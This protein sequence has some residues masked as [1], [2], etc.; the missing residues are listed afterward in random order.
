MPSIPIFLPSEENSETSDGEEKEGGQEKEGEQEKDVDEEKESTETNPVLFKV[1][2]TIDPTQKFIEVNHEFIERR[3]KLLNINNKM[4]KYQEQHEK[5]NKKDEKEDF[6]LTQSLNNSSPKNEADFF[7]NSKDSLMTSHNMISFECNNTV[8][9]CASSDLEY[10]SVQTDPILPN[11]VD[12]EPYEK[13][14]DFPETSSEFFDNEKESFSSNPS[15]EESPPTPDVTPNKGYAEVIREFNAVVHYVKDH[16]ISDSYSSQV[17]HSFYNLDSKLSILAVFQADFNFTDYNHHNYHININ[18]TKSLSNDIVGSLSILVSMTPEHIHNATFYVF[19]HDK[20]P[21]IITKPSTEQSAKRLKLSKSAEISRSLKS[22]SF[23]QF[24]SYSTSNRRSYFAKGGGAIYVHNTQD[25]DSL[26][27]MRCT[28]ENNKCAGTFEI[29][30]DLLFSGTNMW[31]SLHDS[32][33]APQKFSYRQSSKSKGENDGLQAILIDSTFPEID[34]SDT[35]FVA[36]NTFSEAPPIVE[37]NNTDPEEDND[38]DYQPNTPFPS[39]SPEPTTKSHTPRQTTIDMLSL[40]PKQSEFPTPVAS[41]PST[42]TPTQ[43]ASASRSFF[44][45][46]ATVTETIIGSI[47]NTFTRS[48][49]YSI[50]ITYSLTPVFQTTYTATQT[51]INGYLTNTVLS[52]LSNYYS[53]QQISTLTLTIADFPFT[54]ISFTRT[55]IGDV[56]I[57]PKDEEP[58][59]KMSTGTLIGLIVGSVASF[60]L[61]IL[62]MIVT[63]KFLKKQ[64]Q[65]YYSDDQEFIEE[66]PSIV[67][68]K[69]KNPVFMKMNYQ[70]DSDPFNIDFEE[71]TLSYS[72]DYQRY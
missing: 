42:S 14:Q 24:F 12:K 30:Y 50:H 37:V 23:G 41:P 19:Q 43:S 48:Q 57:L 32:F 64:S 29:S 59:F 22:S 33:S 70:W 62:L 67:K 71:V 53:Y 15:N 7:S 47:V 11:T 1:D 51:Y 17:L 28:F 58:R 4:H 20:S 60:L 44:F 65:T 36:S 52:F 46:S 8:N 27:T 55:V 38:F 3:N 68:T 13:D 5:S 40:P 21:V 25:I 9:E 72:P 18:Y 61:L 66:V 16:G 63:V 6:S 56:I 49:T 10:I 34:D 54:F 69:M 31:I 35:Y 39:F 26:K 45:S 2:N